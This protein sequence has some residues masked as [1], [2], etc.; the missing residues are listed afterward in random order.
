MRITN[1][2]RIDSQTQFLPTTKEDWSRLRPDIQKFNQQ[3]DKE[4]ISICDP[5]DPPQSHPMPLW[6]DGMNLF[7]EVY[8]SGSPMMPVVKIPDYKKSCHGWLTIEEFVKQGGEK[9]ISTDFSTESDFGY[10]VSERSGYGYDKTPPRKEG[11]LTIHVFAMSCARNGGLPIIDLQDKTLQLNRGGRVFASQSRFEP[12]GG[13]AWSIEIHNKTRIGN[14]ITIQSL[15]R[16]DWKQYHN[17]IVKLNNRLNN[18]Y[19]VNQIVFFD[20]LE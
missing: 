18:N 14:P 17:D 13:I 19:G 12:I 15:K 10:E 3:K 9:I 20:P 11:I 2:A 7:P 16:D 6:L 1:G 8:D 4:N 5:V